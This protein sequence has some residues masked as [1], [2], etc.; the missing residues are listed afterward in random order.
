MTRQEILDKIKKLFALGDSSRNPNEGEVKT[1]LAMAQKLMT[2]NNL[3]LSEIDFEE[4]NKERIAEEKTN[5][6]QTISFWERKLAYMVAVLFDCEAIINNGYYRSRGWI[7]LGIEEEA[8]LAKEC[9]EYLNNNLR[10]LANFMSKHKLQFYEG[11]TDRLQERINEEIRLRT[12]KETSK[13]TAIICLKNKL[14]ET[15]KETKMKLTNEP[16][17]RPIIDMNSEDYT[18]GYIA[19]GS[20]DLQ[21]KPKTEN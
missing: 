8:K 11:I 5:M 13:C 20:L 2:E 10:L 18:K 21:N 3:S 17:K 15:Y 6:K 7:F 19:G 14:I 12:P 16:Y 4:K 9:Y 1:A